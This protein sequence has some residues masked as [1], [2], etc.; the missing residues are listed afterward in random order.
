MTEKVILNLN[1]NNGNPTMVGSEYR[2]VLQPPNNDN[3]YYQ[4][5][6]AEIPYSFYAINSTN[7]QFRITT[8]T[9]AHTLDV[10]I[11]P[12]NYTSSTLAT[13]ILSNAFVSLDGAA[14]VTTG[15]NGVTAGSG[16]VWG[17][18][19]QDV[20]Y[21]PQGVKSKY[22]LTSVSGAFF[23]TAGPQNSADRILGLNYSTTLGVL[24]ST[25]SAQTSVVIGGSNKLN[26]PVVYNVSGT[27][28]IFL[29]CDQLSSGY[30]YANNTLQSLLIKIPILTAA[31]GNIFYQQRL[32]SEWTEFCLSPLQDYSTLDLSLIDYQLNPIDLNGQDWSCTIGFSKTNNN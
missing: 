18:T 31:G 3:R 6:S 22:T 7:N 9:V 28:Y 25:T 15:V 23:V 13:C 21:D 1:S 29:K 20:T 17:L 27:P 2:I 12:G 16:Y 5:L 10:T 8:T 11:P 24:P 4:I 32:V 26:F 30:N 19:T 14:Y